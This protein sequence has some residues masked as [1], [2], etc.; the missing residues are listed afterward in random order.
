MISL[1]NKCQLPF[2]NETSTKTA[3]CI[4]LLLLRKTYQ[5]SRSVLIQVTIHGSLLTTSGNVVDWFD[6]QG[7]LRICVKH[8]AINVAWINTAHNNSCV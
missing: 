8:A 2:S 1:E 3:Q 6:L 5:R 4:K 7:E